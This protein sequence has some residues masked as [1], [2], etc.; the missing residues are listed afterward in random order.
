M[1]S[2]DFGACLLAF[3]LVAVIV[4]AVTAMS[5]PPQPRLQ[6]PEGWRRDLERIYMND[7]TAS[8]RRKDVGAQIAIPG[9][10]VACLGLAI[11]VSSKRQYTGPQYPGPPYSGPQYI[12]QAPLS[13]KSCSAC[14][15]VM[16][17]DAAYCFNCGAFLGG[18]NWPGA[19]A[20]R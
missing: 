15:R 3:G 8:Q 14:Q 4:G 10:L 9:L 1:N 17:G 5:S 20:G 6:E 7:P 16:P 13:P 18:G 12:A 2:R 11:M 19:N